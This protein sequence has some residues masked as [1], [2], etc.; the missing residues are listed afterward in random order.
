MSGP[1][2]ILR[3][4]Y[5]LS[6]RWKLVILVC[7]K[8]LGRT[9]STNFLGH[10]TMK[11]LPEGSHVTMSGSSCDRRSINACGKGFCWFSVLR[12]LLL[13][14]SPVVEHSSSE[15][16]LD[17]DTWD[18]QPSVLNAVVVESA[19]VLETTTVQLLVV[20]M[21]RR[22]WLPF[23]WS[24]AMLGTNMMMIGRRAGAVLKRLQVRLFWR[25]S[26]NYE[27]LGQDLGWLWRAFIHV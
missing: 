19:G 15:E 23:S 17:T 13:P 3:N 18:E 9:N 1:S 14:R 2:A 22:P 20:S 27:R 21:K 5:M 4:P 12:P 26:K 8:N 25:R 11:A 6:C 7:L 24:G 16:A 10:R